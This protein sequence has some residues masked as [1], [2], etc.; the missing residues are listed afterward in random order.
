VVDS[1][2]GGVCKSHV[3]WQFNGVERILKGDLEQWDMAED[4]S[5]AALNI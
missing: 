3:G 1:Y 2:D 4:R 5:V